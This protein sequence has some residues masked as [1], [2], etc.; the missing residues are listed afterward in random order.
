MNGRVNS[1]FLTIVIPSVVNPKGRGERLKAISETWGPASNAIYVMHADEKIPDGYRWEE[2]REHYPRV[3]RL[4]I[5]ITHDSGVER[6]Q[7]VMENLIEDSAAI[8]QSFDY[9]LFVND[10]TFVIPEHMCAFIQNFGDGASSDVYAGHALMNKELKY[11]FNSGASGYVISRRTLSR[12][13]SAMKNNLEHC[14]V[15]GNIKWIQGNPGIMIAA[16]LGETLSTPP[17]DTRDEYGEHIFHAF[18][19]VRS[20]SGKVDDWYKRKH[21]ELLFRE[22]NEDLQSLLPSGE[23]CCSAKTV[24]FHY[25]EYSETRALYKARKYIMESNFMAHPISSE[26]LSDW[27]QKNWPERNKVGGYS[28]TLPRKNSPERLAVMNVL[29]KI[30]STKTDIPSQCLQLMPFN[31]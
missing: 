2:E 8:D 6:L 1:Q 4:P 31:M 17:I 25:V 15:M 9:A 23:K 21:E 28:H 14:S 27:L 11:G 22:E 30:S 3:M 16:C 12:L 5:H 19:I 10:H 20:V 7:Y 24:S 26:V 13:V 29:R 18:G